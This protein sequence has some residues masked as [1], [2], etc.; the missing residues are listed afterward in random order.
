MKKEN[1]TGTKKTR[2]AREKRGAIHF[3][4]PFVITSR[5]APDSLDNSM[6][7]LRYSF[8]T[9]RGMANLSA[10]DLPGVDLP[11][12]RAIVI[13]GSDIAPS[14]LEAIK[15]KR[16]ELSM[17][18]LERVSLPGYAGAIPANCF[19]GCS[20]LK[21]LDAPA[22]TSVG[23]NAFNG[24][25]FS[26]IHLPLVT[27][28]GERAFMNCDHL[29]AARFPAVTSITGREAFRG[30]DRLSVAHFPRLQEI[31][32]YMFWE[33]T[34]LR[35]A[36]FPAATVIGEGAFRVT[37]LI[38]A[39]FPSAATIRAAAFAACSSLTA[40]DLPSATTIGEN[41][42]S[43]CYRLTSAR[44]PLAT[45]VGARAFGDCILLADLWFGGGPVHVDATA[46]EGLDTSQ[47]R[48]SGED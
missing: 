25:G 26:T 40:V 38:I 46:F 14:H 34:S 45:S 16:E 11:A 20:W 43:H 28:I 33:C 31:G 5:T 19:I 9:R 37:G 27:S 2:Y 3:A 23:K 29:L 36:G 24:A 32:E 13:E 39:R 4:A 44:L 47:V 6:L 7:T 48:L 15:N 21:H 30:C 41:A 42:F 22:A 17:N 1:N 18:S 12:T 8:M 10:A 35:S